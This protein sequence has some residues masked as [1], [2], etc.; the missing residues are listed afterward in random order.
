MVK[1]GEGFKREMGREL[2]KSLCPL[3]GTVALATPHHTDD[4]SRDCLP[5]VKGW[6]LCHVLCT[7]PRPHPHRALRGGRRYCPRLRREDTEGQCSRSHSSPVTFWPA[8]QRLGLCNCSNPTCRRGRLLGEQLAAPGTGGRETLRE[9]SHVCW[10]RRGR[11][12]SLSGREREHREG[13]ASQCYRSVRSE[14]EDLLK[15]S[16]KEPGAA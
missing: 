13:L 16:S 10:S 9:C 2:P 3:V 7:D 14:N 11:D 4:T 15:L 1:R 12:G 8:G 5:T 6:A